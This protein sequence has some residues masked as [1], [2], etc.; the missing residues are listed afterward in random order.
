VGRDS[1][2]VSISEL[3]PTITKLE[4]TATERLRAL[5]DERGV[6]WDADDEAMDDGS[7]SQ[8]TYWYCNGIEWSADGRDEY[9]AF[10]AV[11][12][13]TPEQAIAA[14][15]GREDIYTREDMEGAF[16]SCYSLGSL[17][18]GSDPRWD[19]NRQTVDE[20]MAELGWVRKEA[21]TLG[22]SDATGA[23]RSD[24]V[25]VVRCR[26]CE[27]Y[28]ERINGCVE[29]GDESR[30]EYANVEP[31]GFCAWGERKEA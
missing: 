5:L 22:G 13:L 27:H 9:L 29:F 28:R 18:V 17:P 15:L 25:E 4:P 26:D 7:L 6:E 3:E 31:D 11:Q 8:V 21:A 19:E 10:D 12:L 30:G 16:V 2:E 23:R 14:T 24:A 1:G 20:H